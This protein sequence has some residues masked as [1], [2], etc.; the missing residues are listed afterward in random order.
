MIIKYGWRQALFWASHL[1]SAG[2]NVQQLR[3]LVAVSDCGSVSRAARLLC[4]TQPV[5]SRSI[6]AFEVEHGVTVFCLSG[7]CLVPTEAGLAVVDAARDALAAVEAVGLK[8]R[9]AGKRAELVISTTPTNG[10]LLTSAL[11]E[12]GRNERDLEISVRRAVDA[13]DVRGKVQAR[14]AEI[15]FSELTPF[16]G[17]GQLTVRPIAELDIVLVSPLDSGLPAAVSWDDVVTQP[18]IM[19]PVSS[20]RRQ[21][22]DDMATR[23][24]G[25]TAQASLVIE[26]R[27]S[28]IAAAQAGMGSFLSYQSVVHGHEGIEVRPFDPPQSVTVGFVHRAGPITKAAVQLMDLA[29]AAHTGRLAS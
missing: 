21:L 15:G 1:C 17:D 3:Y 19:P 18:L 9:T 20:G 11:G 13:Q 22:I 28:W 24:T 16:A 8:A 10:L 29:Q 27:G 5:I 23:E 7:R 6:R 25:T 14:E 2:M 12:L 26:D 4:V